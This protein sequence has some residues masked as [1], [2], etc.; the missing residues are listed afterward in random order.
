M[1][2]HIDIRESRSTDLSLIEAIYPEAFPDEELRPL[3]RSLLRD[4]TAVLSLVACVD[5]RVVGHV[6]FTP[7]GLENRTD[8]V[9]LLG[10]LAVLPSH[11]KQGVGSA[12]VRA[13]HERLANAGVTAIYVLGD[14]AYYGRFGY[15]AED[16]VT[17]PYPL[18][19]EWEGAWQALSLKPS[20]RP[21]AGVLR[22]P[23][24][25][26]EPALWAP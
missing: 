22:V 13:G 11:H 12:L 10:P 15:A 21:L 25:W 1:I 16:K 6:I 20:D 7:C 24:P 17:P 5:G 19:A 14:P 3:V 26:A 4:G 9:A 8:A 23:A 2:Q 18:P